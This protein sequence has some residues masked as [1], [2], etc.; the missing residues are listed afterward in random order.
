MPEDRAINEN[1]KPKMI[2]NKSDKN[3]ISKVTRE[4]LRTLGNIYNIKSVSNIYFIKS[5]LVDLL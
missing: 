5:I 3:D 2:L 4:A 1:S